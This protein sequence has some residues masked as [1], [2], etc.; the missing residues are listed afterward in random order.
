MWRWLRLQSQP[1]LRGGASVNAVVMMAEGRYNNVAAV[2]RQLQHAAAHSCV[3][4]L[5]FGAWK[6]E[7]STIGGCCVKPWLAHAPPPAALI[8][9]AQP[10]VSPP[11]R[12]VLKIIFSS[13]P[14]FPT[15]CPP[16]P[17]PPFPSP[18]HH[19]TRC[20]ALLPHSHRLGQTLPVIA[21]P[22]CQP[23]PDT[24]SSSS[25]DSSGIDSELAV[26]LSES[27]PAFDQLLLTLQ[28]QHQQQLQW[29]ESAAGR[30]AAAVWWPF[31]QHAQLPNK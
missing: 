27:A 28:Q 18:T 6:E 26:W 5:L 22:L 4:L 25:I 17:P 30:A 12:G 11:L 16:P 2:Q 1:T 10:I 23:P 29:L 15:A 9:A 7:A 20:P 14:P 3:L 8:T 21:L 19:H 13:P 24:K 31:T